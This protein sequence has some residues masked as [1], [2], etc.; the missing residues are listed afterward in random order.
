MKSRRILRRLLSYG[1]FPRELPPTLSTRAFGLVLTRRWKQKPSR[2]D[3]AQVVSNPGK[4]SVVR[5]GP[6]RRSL[7]LLNPISFAGLASEIADAWEV[8]EKTYGKSSLSKSRPTF[9]RKGARAFL[10]LVNQGDLV[11]LRARVRAGARVLIQTDIARFY[12]SIYTHSVP[13]ALHGKLEA[14]RRQRDYALQGNRIDRALRNSSGGQTIGIPIGPDTSLLIAELILSCIDA[15]LRSKYVFQ[16]FRYVDDYEIAVTTQGQADSLVANLQQLLTEYEL[17][18]NALKTRVIELPV[19]HEFSWASKIRTHRIR[20]HP[21]GQASDLVHL[22]D[23]AFARA[24]ETPTAPVL[25]YLMGRLKHEGINLHNWRLYQDLL[26]ESMTI[27]PATIPGAMTT[28]LRHVVKGFGISRSAFSATL[29]GIIGFHAP[30]SH[31]NE[32]AWAI[33]SLMT[34]NLRIS[35]EAAKSISELPDSAVALLALH[36]EELDLVE[37]ELDK[38]RWLEIVATPEVA[39]WDEYWLLTYEAI[40][41]GWL[42]VDPQ[43]IHDDPAFGFLASLGVRF[44]DLSG[45]VEPTPTG[46]PPSAG[47]APAFYT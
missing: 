7:S 4:H 17:E 9:H 27:E 19:D 13:W 8:L 3:D 15:S 21:I 37:G 38:S 20:S 6:L 25:R 40:L 22:F 33:W 29:N 45:V 44:Y 10:P 31:A 24:R 16:G 43:P 23:L 11:R 32:V 42:P 35:E 28:V 41:R 34:L 26:L 47:F 5:S 30:L 46:V 12:H 2:F 39:L 18:L 36:A 14:K 1:Y